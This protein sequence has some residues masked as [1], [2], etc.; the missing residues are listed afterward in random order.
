[1]I[2]VKVEMSSSPESFMAGELL[3]SHSHGRRAA[4]QQAS[5]DLDAIHAAE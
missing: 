5:L 3:R 2:Q 1:M 4:L